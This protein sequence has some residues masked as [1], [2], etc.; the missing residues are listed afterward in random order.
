MNSQY[1]WK[2]YVH[3]Q[4]TLKND[5]VIKQPV[6]IVVD[7][8][9]R[10]PNSPFSLK[11]YGPI[12]KPDNTG[13]FRTSVITN[14]MNKEIE[15]PQNIVI[16]VRESLGKWRPYYISTRNR[17]TSKLSKNEIEIDLG[18]VAIDPEQSMYLSQ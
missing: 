8:G 14:G 15:A 17:Q 11:S 3:G 10:D 18:K 7:T 1:H 6:H 2:I 12:G 13:T 5:N 9:E 16:H 4:L